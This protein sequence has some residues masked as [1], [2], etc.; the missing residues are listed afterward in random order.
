MHPS[1]EFS[2]SLNYNLCFIIYISLH[3]N[4]KCTLWEVIVYHYRFL[5]SKVYRNRY[6]LIG[7]GPGVP[8]SISWAVDIE[9][10]GPGSWVLFLDY[11]VTEP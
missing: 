8:G 7:I 4:P 5:S 1:Y 9:I 2:G 10:L 6:Y 3:D 11:A